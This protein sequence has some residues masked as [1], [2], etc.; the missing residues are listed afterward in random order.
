ML[1]AFTQVRARTFRFPATLGL[2]VSMLLMTALLNNANATVYRWEDAKGRVHYSKIVPP[3]YQDVAT[4]VDVRAN[5]PTAE[6]RQEALERA[7]GNKARLAAIK[8]QQESAPPE[9]PATNLSAK[10]PAQVPNAQTDCKTW[11]R[12]YKES[13]AC[14][15]PYRTV[16]G[17]LKA[18]AFDACNEVLQPPSPRC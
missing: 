7:K 17:G 9:L 5:E 2:A 10:R 15:G 4:P 6:Q 3:Q 12:L 8:K 18:E 14:F 1:L 11:G 16:G 13:M